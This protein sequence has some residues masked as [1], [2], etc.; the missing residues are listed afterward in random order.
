M[1]IL[2]W[3][4]LSILVGVYASSKGRS[5]IGFFFLSIILSPLIGFIIA[6]IV[7]PKERQGSQLR[8]CPFCAEDIKSEAIVCKHCGRD[9]EPIKKEFRVSSDEQ[10]EKCPKCGSRSVHPYTG[11]C[12]Q[13][14]TITT[15]PK[16]EVG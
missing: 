9:V 2:T 3:I 4:V 11:F 15:N 16:K 6:L 5:G 7:Q 12:D 14:F 1:W 13:C 10:L 8:K